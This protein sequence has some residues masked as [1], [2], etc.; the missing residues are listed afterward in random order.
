MINSSQSMEIIRRHQKSAPVHVVPIAEAFGLAVY[1]ATNWPDA[2]SGMIVRDTARGGSSG[3]AIYVN[4][5]HSEVRRRFTIAHEIAHFALHRDLIGDGITEDALYRSGF[6]DAVE[7]EAN[8][9]AAEILMP[10]QL[11]RETFNSGI[12][13]A[14]KLAEK[15]NVSL[16]A[17]EFRLVNLHLMEMA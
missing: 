2:T 9:L 3:F 13:S 14:A 8:G 5:V 4:A 7:R 6:S 1:R 10:K 17:M 15:F 11:V 12:R 16:Q